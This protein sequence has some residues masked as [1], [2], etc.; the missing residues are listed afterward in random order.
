MSQTH[1]K[2]ITPFSG[3]L[4]VFIAIELTTNEIVV[5]VVANNTSISR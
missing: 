1:R 5:D 4:D 2:A 3:N